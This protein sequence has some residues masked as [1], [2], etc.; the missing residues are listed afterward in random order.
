MD[1]GNGRGD[2]LA[3]HQTKLILNYFSNAFVDILT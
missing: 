2:S 3:Q 1:D